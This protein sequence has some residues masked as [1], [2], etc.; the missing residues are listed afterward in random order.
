MKKRLFALVLAAALLLCASCTPAAEVTP[1]PTL[2][3]SPTPT[4]TPEPP[5]A[6]EWSGDGYSYTSEALGIKLEFP[7]GWDSYFTIEETQ[8]VDFLYYFSDKDGWGDVAEGSTTVLELVPKYKS[9]LLLG[10]ET[11]GSIYWMPE[12]TADSASANSGTTVTLWA[13]DEGRLVCWMDTMPQNLIG[14]LTIDDT[15]RMAT[16]AMF[17]AVQNGIKDG[18][19][20]IELLK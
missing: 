13:S 4:A 14:D 8:K 1:S 11:F 6:H 10:T 2:E 12:G 17:E 20:E 16:F 19:W 3:L 7:W 9:P 15:E 5:P 18:R